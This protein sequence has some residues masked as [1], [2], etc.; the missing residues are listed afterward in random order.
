MIR[1][2]LLCVT[3]GDTFHSSYGLF[4]R[5]R[6]MIRFQDIYVDMPTNTD[7]PL[8]VRKISVVI[9]TLI[10]TITDFPQSLSLNRNQ[11]KPTVDIEFPHPKI[12][13][14]T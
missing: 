10:C 11:K 12:Q 5:I 8:N 2:S 6:Y 14:N 9:L 1:Y 7:L 3:E 4:T 13:Q